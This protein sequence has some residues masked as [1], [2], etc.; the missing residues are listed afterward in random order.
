MKILFFF[1]VFLCGSGLVA[2]EDVFIKALIAHESNGNDRAVGDTHLANR[3][4]GCLQVR[5][6]CLDDVNRIYRTKY[7]VKDCIGNRELSVWICKAY[8][9]IYA[10]ESRL[11]R[12]PTAEDCARI[13]N[14]G[15]DGWKKESTLG[16][17]E[18]VKKLLE[19]KNL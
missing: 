7:Q 16:Y 6:P 10:K 3:A 4:Y 9:A 5:K 14:G 13:W 12:V 11:G 8:L 17:W 2:S 18:K 15:P 1:C 19:K